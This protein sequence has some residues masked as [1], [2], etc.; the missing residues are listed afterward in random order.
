MGYFS[1]GTPYARGEIC[2]RSNL[3]IP[4]YYKNELET[5]K[6]IQDGY[7]SF[8]STSLYIKFSCLSR[9]A[10]PLFLMSLNELYFVRWFLTGDIGEMLPNG[11]VRI[12]DRRKNFFKLAQGEFIAPE[13]L[14]NVFLES[15]FID[16]IF[17]YGER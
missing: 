15:P 16:Q 6:S 9:F 2:V 1:T 10:A 13:R 12:I 11:S 8:H 14:E 17:I 5:N 3:V 4:G 7:V